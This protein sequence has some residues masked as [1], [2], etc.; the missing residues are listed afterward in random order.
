MRYTNSCGI[1]I[2]TM[3]S[4]VHTWGTSILVGHFE[5]RKGAWC[6]RARSARL[7]A[8]VELHE[9]VMRIGSDETRL[10]A[11]LQST[12]FIFLDRFIGRNRC[13]IGSRKIH[14]P[15]DPSRL[16]SYGM[17]FHLGDLL[18]SMSKT[19]GSSQISGTTCPVGSTVQS[20]SAIGTSF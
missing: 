16:L 13:T 5:V 4:E 20:T 17:F 2:I 9:S 19:H 15:K 14:Y 10:R 18:P 11:Y 1:S 12:V 3:S 7:D 8:R 6:K